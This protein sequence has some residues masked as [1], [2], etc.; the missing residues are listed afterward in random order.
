ML[1]FL[2][3]GYKL[4]KAYYWEIVVMGRKIS[5]VFISIFLRQF[6]TTVQALLASLLVVFIAIAHFH[7]HPFENPTLDRLEAMGLIGSYITIYC[8]LFFKSE[9]LKPEA[10]IALV[11]ILISVNVAYMCYFSTFLMEEFKAKAKS[12]ALKITKKKKK[13]KKKTGKFSLVQFR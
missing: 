4:D 11:I 10:Q 2:Y 12:I 13:K 1:G 9:E 7:I 5:V 6:G 8:G 3:V